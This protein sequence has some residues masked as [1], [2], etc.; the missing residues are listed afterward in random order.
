MERG[1]LLSHIDRVTALCDTSGNKIKRSGKGKIPSHLHNTDRVIKWSRGRQPLRHSVNECVLSGLPEWSPLHEGV[2]P[3]HSS[4]APVQ[5]LLFKQRG[6]SRSRIVDVPN[7][8]E[9]QQK[10]QKKITRSRSGRFVAPP[11]KSPPCK[12]QARHH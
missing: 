3:A 11:C 12:S 7:V 9:L 6:R 4:V 1:K 8:K 5:T 2:R 10:G